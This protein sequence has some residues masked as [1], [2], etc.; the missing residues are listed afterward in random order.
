MPAVGQV[1]ARPA[2]DKG[3]GRL[4]SAQRLLRAVLT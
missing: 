3:A 2:R 4:A 1:P